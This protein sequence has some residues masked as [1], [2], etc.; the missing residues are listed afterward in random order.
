MSA[1]QPPPPPHRYGD[2]S[3]AVSATAAEPGWAG[4]WIEPGLSGGLTEGMHHY[5]QTCCLFPD[6]HKALCTGRRHGD[7]HGRGTRSVIGI[8]PSSN[9]RA[10]TR[11]NALNVRTSSLNYVSAGG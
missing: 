1:V 4:G 2:V 5:Y 11:A 8:D 7:G 9:L 10:P 3:A 6:V